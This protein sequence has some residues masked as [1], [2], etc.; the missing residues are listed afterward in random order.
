MVRIFAPASSC[1]GCCWAQI[2]DRV[3]R[4]GK[5]LARTMV[6]IAAGYVMGQRSRWVGG[7]EV[8]F[9]M[10]ERPRRVC[11][12]VRVWTSLHLNHSNLILQPSWVGLI[13]SKAEGE[14]YVD[15]KMQKN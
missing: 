5:V 6:H 3:K 15:E 10:R 9:R 11:C 13:S 2:E 1:M 12:D 7:G 4:A 14:R 8:C